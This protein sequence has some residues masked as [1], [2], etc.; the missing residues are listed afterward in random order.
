[1]TSCR[2]NRPLLSVKYRRKWHPERRL[3]TVTTEEIILLTFKTNSQRLLI[4]SFG[5]WTM[6]AFHLM[7]MT[8]RAIASLSYHAI[9]EPVTGEFVLYPIIHLPRTVPFTRRKATS[10]S[11][12]PKDYLNTREYNGFGRAWAATGMG[13]IGFEIPP[14]FWSPKP[15]ID[16]MLWEILCRR[17]C[18]LGFL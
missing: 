9:W 6:G 4:F 8:R 17:T 3:A 18:A 12:F 1:M 10:F 11:C 5:K 7:E 15:R 16:P 2:V 13:T 14:A